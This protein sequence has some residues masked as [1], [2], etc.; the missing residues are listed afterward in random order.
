M[1]RA[2][3]LGDDLVHHAEF[4]QLGRGDA[5]RLRRRARLVARLPQDRGAGLRGRDVVDRVLH[6]QVVVGA[7]DGQRAAGPALADDDRQDR[8][9]EAKHLAEV[10]RDG[11]ALARLLGGL[12]REGAG[13]VD[14]S[15][16]GEAKVV[17]VAHE[18][19]SFAVAVGLRHAEVAVDVLLGVAPLLVPDEHEGHAVHRREAA[20]HGRVVEPGAV[21][22]ELDE[23]VRD[24]ERDVEE[25]RAVGV[26]RDGE[27]LRR[28]E[29]GV[30]V[31]AELL[32]AGLE[33]LDGLGDVDAVLLGDAADLS[34]GFSFGVLAGRGVKRGK[35]GRGESERKRRKGR[36][37]ERE[38]GK[39]VGRGCGVFFFERPA[40]AERRPQKGKEREITGFLIKPCA[41][42]LLLRHPR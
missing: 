23:L 3:R 11:L 22:V 21:A 41:R 26:A 6:D 10:D 24:V 39:K 27:A 35:E 32:G 20:D 42:F 33:L 7:A 14:E 19:Q 1:R 13:R 40:A 8:H 17:R 29:A 38:V 30:G 16:D 4:E 12:A 15:H 9:A 5:Q 18:A 36:E 37:A 28:R 34:G 2:E 25:G 31:L